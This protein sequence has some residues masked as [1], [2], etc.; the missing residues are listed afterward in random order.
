MIIPMFS[1]GCLNSELWGARAESTRH[2]FCTR[3]GAVGHRCWPRPSR[4]RDLARGARGKSIRC[5]GL[6]I[7][8]GLHSPIRPH[9]P[10]AI[11]QVAFT[12]V[13]HSPPLALAPRSLAPHLAELC[14]LHLDRALVVVPIV[15][16]LVLLVPAAGVAVAAALHARIALH[17]PDAGLQVAL[18]VVGHGPTRALLAP[19]DTAQP[20]ASLSCGVADRALVVAAPVV[21]PVPG[22]PAVVRRCRA[23]AS[24]VLAEAAGGALRA[25]QAEL[26]GVRLRRVARD[27][28]RALQTIRARFTAGAKLPGR[29]RWARVHARRGRRRRA[30]VLAEAAGGALRAVAAKL[31]GV[32]LRRVAR[33]VVRALQAIRARFTAGA[34][35]PG[36]ARWAR[37]H[38]R[39][40]RQRRARVPAEAAG[41]AL[42]TVGAELRWVRLRRV[43]RD[44]VRAL[45]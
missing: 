44:I 30:R 10:N 33:D 29:A 14:V 5:A 24:R 34:E 43:A 13:G 25:V 28:V 26:R 42:R 32:R 7:A 2:A 1:C 15:V 41:G 4:A 22:A 27:V 36:R 39:R 9:G 23:E 21:V 6:A 17:V 38:A 35:L 45:Q 37:V 31:R 18:V 19:A 40:G 8:A 3:L 16:L 12:V 11:L 20:L